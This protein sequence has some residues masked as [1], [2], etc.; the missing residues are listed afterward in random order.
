MGSVQRRTSYPPP[1]LVRQTVH[2]QTRNHNSHTRPT[3]PRLFRGLVLVLSLAY[4]LSSNSLAVLAATSRLPAQLHHQEQQLLHDAEQKA[5]LADRVTITTPP[6]P[7]RT[8]WMH[9]HWKRASRTAPATCENGYCGNGCI[10][11]GAFCCNPGGNLAQ[12]PQC[13][14]SFFGRLG[15]NSECPNVLYVR[16][17]EVNANILSI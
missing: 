8:Q 17:G 16:I 9:H 12:E 14:L 7:S 15:R 5:R 6:D 11:D 2:H 13:M 3:L 4:F 10:P 1:P